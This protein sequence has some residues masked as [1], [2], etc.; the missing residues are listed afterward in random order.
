MFQN[1]LNHQTNKVKSTKTNEKIKE[2]NQRER[3][4]KNRQ[5]RERMMN[6]FY[7]ENDGLL[8]RLKESTEITTTTTVEPE[9][10]IQRNPN[11]TQPVIWVLLVNGI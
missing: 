9:K 5:K 3:K 7:L 6:E 11:P 8:R 4:H 2:Q 1:S 10:R